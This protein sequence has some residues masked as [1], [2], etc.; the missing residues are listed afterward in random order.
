MTKTEVENKK[1]KIEILTSVA[2]IRLTE[3]DDIICE[4]V[5]SG[6]LPKHEQNKIYNIILQLRNILDI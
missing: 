2:L 5:N 3:A 6:K 4:L 1:T